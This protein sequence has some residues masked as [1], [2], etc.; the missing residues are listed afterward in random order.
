MTNQALR[1]RSTSVAPAGERSPGADGDPAR[2]GAA[3]RA[4]VWVLRDG[5]P[6][7]V[8]VVAGLDDEDFTEIVSGELK[9]D[10]RVIV[11]E[12]RQAAGARRVPMPKL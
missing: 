1:Y 8:P 9:A 4:R 6:I 7:R 12:Q 5:K 10:D 2:T 11:S 3:D